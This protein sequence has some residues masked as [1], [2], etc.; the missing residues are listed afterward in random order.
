MAAHGNGDADT[1]GLDFPCR[2]DIKAMGKHT[3]QFEALVRDIVARHVS[4]DHLHD[5]ASRP[6]KENTYVSI[7]VTITAVGYDQLNAIYHE[8]S[9]NPDVLFAL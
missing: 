2:I 1:P 6:S 8:L 5:V 9:G 7:T 3:P 4:A